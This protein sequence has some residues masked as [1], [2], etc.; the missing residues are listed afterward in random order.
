MLFQLDAGTRPGAAAPRQTQQHR[1]NTPHSDA[2]A[3]MTRWERGWTFRICW[4]VCALYLFSWLGLGL[5]SGAA[6]GAGVP[7]LAVCVLPAAPVVAAVGADS[8]LQRF[9][10]GVSSLGSEEDDAQ[11]H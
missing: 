6:P 8:A 3:G 2:V 5:A 11:E 7:H 10:D 4:L 9:A 1:T